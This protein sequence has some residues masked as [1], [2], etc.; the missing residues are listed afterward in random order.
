MRKKKGKSRAVRRVRE[1]ARDAFAAV[2][3]LWYLAL[4]LAGVAYAVNYL[5]KYEWHHAMIMWVVPGV[6]GGYAVVQ[7]Y[8]TLAA[9][10]AVREFLREQDP[11]AARAMIDDIQPSVRALPPRVRARYYER[12]AEL[13]NAAEGSARERSARDHNA[14]GACH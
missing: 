10:V 2:R 9:R 8:K 12:R 1:A 6:V 3:P 11:H 7:L 13:R 4:A 5:A 14:G